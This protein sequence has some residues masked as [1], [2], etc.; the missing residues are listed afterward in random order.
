MVTSVMPQRWHHCRMRAALSRLGWPGKPPP[1]PL[2][3][4]LAASALPVASTRTTPR[5]QSSASEGELEGRAVDPSDAAMLQASRGELEDAPVDS[6]SSAAAATRASAGCGEVSGGEDGEEGVEGRR[7]AC[8]DATSASSARPAPGGT[9]AAPAA[10]RDS[11]D[12]SS[13]DLA[14]VLPRGAGSGA[15]SL[16]PRHLGASLR[17]GSTSPSLRR[18]GISRSSAGL[19]ALQ[20]SGPQLAGG[21]GAPRPQSS[22]REQPQQLKS[23]SICMAAKWGAMAA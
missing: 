23:Q 6:C 22:R 10:E 1:L 13:R 9:R 19:D 5:P 7:G 17:S 8:V 2:P 15:K 18:G 14:E 16:R 11:D 4:L 21:P 20:L 3:L 12:A